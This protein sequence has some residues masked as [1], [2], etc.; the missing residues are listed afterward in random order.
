MSPPRLGLEAVYNPAWPAGI[1]YIRNLVYALAALSDE[2]PPVRLLPRDVAS[3]KE[4]VDLDR[5]GFA[6]I[7]AAGRSLDPILGASLFAR[8]VHRKVIQ[9]RVGRATGRAF[10]DLDVTYP[11]WGTPIPGATQIQWIPDLQH[12]HLP[13]LFSPEEIASRDAWI[14]RVAD[15]EG[16]VV[17]S[18]EAALRDMLS[19][20][21]APR[22]QARVWRFCTTITSHEEGGREPR[23]SW[24]LPESYLYVGNQFW[25]HKDHLT[26]FKALRILR[27]RG[28]RQTVVCTG[29]LD[30]YRDPEYVRSVSSFIDEHQLADQVIT[31]GFLDRRDQIQILRSCA[32][33]VQ[34]SRFE[35]WSTVVEDAKS[36]GRPIVISDIAVHKEQDDGS[37]PFRFFE[38][39]SEQALADALMDVIPHLRPG[40]DPEAEDMARERAQ[41]RARKAGEA[42]VEIAVSASSERRRPGPAR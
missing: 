5:F 37:V 18:S 11:E 34:P 17:F 22:V 36:V 27:D 42:F 2:A 15:S 13:H 33:L 20:H 39:G 38:T 26:L 29:R 1:L 32:A 41:A 4:V 23:T 30:D 3:Y 25:A 24:R 6:E 21:P 12:V 14:H 16:T 40:P 9:P 8:R 10:R 28:L 7:P 35:G 19:F 31:L